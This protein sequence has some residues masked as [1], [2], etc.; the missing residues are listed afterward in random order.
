MQEELPSP[1]K[2]EVRDAVLTVTMC[3]QDNRNA[4]GAAMVSALA[5]AL[6]EAEADRSLRALVLTNEGPVFCAGA[7]LK[8]RSRA[9]KPSNGAVAGLGSFGRL[10]EDIKGARLPVIGRIAGHVVGGGMGLAAALDIAV[11][12][13]DV[14][15]GFSEVRLGVIPAIISVVCLEKMRP[16]DAREAFLRGNRFGATRAAELGLISR[17]VGRDQLDEA[18]AEVLA[19]VC[20]GGPEALAAA[21]QL[22]NKVPRMEREEAV[23]WTAELSATI[24]AGEE[25]AEGMTAFLEKRPAAWAHKK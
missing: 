4:L 1:V 14:K 12:V 11:A 25:A 21:K 13:D 20:M 10:I 7:N 17:A 8:E 5:A 18:V 16:G 24:F 22:V 2:V 9:A 15:F 23:K 19:D 3:D 6:A